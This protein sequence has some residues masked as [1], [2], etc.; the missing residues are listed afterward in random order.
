M[1]KLESPGFCLAILQ[2]MS[3]K[4]KGIFLHTLYAV[5]QTHEMGQGLKTMIY[6]VIHAHTP[7]VPI[8]SF[9]DALPPSH[10]KDPPPDHTAFSRHVSLESCVLCGAL[11]DHK[12]TVLWKHPSVCVCFPGMGYD[13]ISHSSAPDLAGLKFTASLI[14][15]GGAPAPSF[16]SKSKS[17]A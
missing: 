14:P 15:G 5:Y 16:Y 4:H 17:K 8:M 10:D 7:V 6:C 1:K 13:S 3:P 11:E 9:I 2:C 12:P